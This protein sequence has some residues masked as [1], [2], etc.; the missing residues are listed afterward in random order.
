MWERR[1]HCACCGFEEHG[2][3]GVVL[4]GGP[5]ID[6][7]QGCR[8]VRSIVS[9]STF[10]DR[11]ILT[12]ALIARRDVGGCSCAY[13]VPREC[14]L[15]RHLW[16]VL[17][18]IVTDKLRVGFA[19]VAVKE[20]TQVSGAQDTGDTLRFRLTGRRWVWRSGSWDTDHSVYTSSCCRDPRSSAGLASERT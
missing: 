11:V 9:Q 13:L 20:N 15:L 19:H 4:G 12:V 6:P 7:Q 1:T 2:A 3:D 17:R 8:A 5:D 18:G 10:W 16:R 14:Q